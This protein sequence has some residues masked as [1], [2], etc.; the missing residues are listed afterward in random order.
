MTAYALRLA[1]SQDTSTRMRFGDMLAL[2]AAGPLQARNG[3]RPDGGGEVSVVAGSMTVQVTPFMAWVQGTS[4]TAQAGYPF[5]LD[6]T[7]T[8]TLSAGDP[9]SDRVDTIVAR[10]QDDAYDSSGATV[11]TVAVVEGVPGAG[12]PA[13]PATC[14]PLRDVTVPA[15]VSAGTGGLVAGN[16]GADRR[17]YVTGLGGVTAVSSTA[18]RDSLPAQAGTVVYRKDTDTLQ[19]YNGTSW[20]TY[21]P[22]A[23]LISKVTWGTATITFQSGGGANGAIDHHLG[24]TPDLC[25][26]TLEQEQQNVNCYSYGPTQFVAHVNNLS[27]GSNAIGVTAVIH[28]VAFKFA[29]TGYT[30]TSTQ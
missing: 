8:L 17:T 21:Y 16:L 2:A 9:A 5:V 26:A 27:D 19:A 11:A 1:N 6:S 29:G 20:D 24:E 28:W 10:V 14:I 23:P 15:G 13:L 18:D 3:L 4:T 30:S 25:L 12:A 7:L 22:G